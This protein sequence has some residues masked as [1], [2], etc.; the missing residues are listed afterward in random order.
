[1]GAHQELYRRRMG[2]RRRASLATSTRP[3]PTISSANMR[4]PTPPRP[5]P[6]SRR[7][8]PRFPPGRGR[9][10]RSGTTSCCAPRTEILARR[11]ELG[12]LLSREEGK[13]LAE[14]D[15]RGDPG[16]ADLRLLRRR[17][18]ADSGREIRQRAAER[19][20]RGDARAG[21]RRRHHRAVELPAR[22]PRLEDRAGARLRQYGR[23]QA[24]RSRARLRPRARRNHRARRRAEGRVQSGHGARLGRRSGDPRPQDTSTRSPSPARSRPAAGSRPPAPSAMRR[25]QLEMGGK[26]PLVVLADAD[27]HERRRMRGQRRLFL[28]RPALH[29]LVAPHRRG[30]DLPALRRCADRADARRSSSTTR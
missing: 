25:F 10:R 19:R 4:R 21:R 27:L 6:R 7:R 5:T 20:H 1:M 8:A 24:G 14:G 18:L 9:R 30:A 22:N 29:R 23:L 28:D 26:N 2:R 3:T 13:T 17:G 11:E 15:R 12:R 16:R